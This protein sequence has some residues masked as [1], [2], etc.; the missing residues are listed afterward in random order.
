M[1]YN[2]D[3]LNFVQIIHDLTKICN[4]VIVPRIIR[5]IMMYGKGLPLEKEKDGIADAGIR[6]VVIMGSIIRIM[7]KLSTHNV[8]KEVRKRMMG[9]F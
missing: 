6:P 9:P 1:V 8:P 2:D 4:T 5:D 3:T 7:D